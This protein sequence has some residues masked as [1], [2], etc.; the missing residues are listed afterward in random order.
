MSGERYMNKQNK[1]QLLNDGQDEAVIYIEELETK[2]KKLIGVL[3]AIYMNF[4]VSEIDK[5]T[6]CIRDAWELGQQL[7][8]K[9]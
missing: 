5:Q 2:N 9:S 6:A 7:Y 4:H 3:T 1:Q 8:T